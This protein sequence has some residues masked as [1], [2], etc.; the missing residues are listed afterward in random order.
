MGAIGVW[1]C[2]RAPASVPEHFAPNG[3]M[4]VSYDQRPEAAWPDQVE[5]VVDRT[6]SVLEPHP[7]YEHQ[8]TGQAVYVLAGEA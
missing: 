7:T 1:A 3:W 6:R 2:A 5:Y 4:L 8:E